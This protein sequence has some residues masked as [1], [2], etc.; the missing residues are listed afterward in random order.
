MK[1][2]RVFISTWKGK[3][4]TGITAITTVCVL[5]SATGGSDLFEIAKNID[6]FTSVYKELNTYY[7]DDVD[8]NK[9]MRTGIDAMLESLDPYTNYI[10]EA[11][12]EGYKFQITGNYGGIG[13]SIRP[14]NGNVTV[15]ECYEGFA[16]DKA[17]LKPGDILLEIDGK[18]VNTL[19][20]DGISDLL[21]GSPGT[22]VTLTIK[23]PFSEETQK[24]DIIREDIDIHNV[25]YYGFVEDGIGYIILTKF[26]EDAGANVADALKKLQAENPGM[27]GVILDLR[28]NPGGLLREAVNVS[29]VFIDKGE[30]VCSTLGKVKDWDKTFSALNNAIDKNIPLVVLINRGSASASEIVSGTIQDYDRGVIIGEKSYGKGLVQ[31]TVD[32]SYKTKLKLTTAKYYIP[33]GRCIQALDYAHRNDDGSVGK[34][35]DS[36]KTAFKTKN[37]RTVYDGGGIDP[38]VEVE[39]QEYRDI[40]ISLLRKNLIFNYATKYVAEHNS[41]AD[42]KH[43]SLSD[44]EYDAFVN[45]LSDKA[46]DYTTDTESDLDYLIA[47]AKSDNYYDA[48]ESDINDLRSKISH[49][50]EN[51]L[52]RS[53]DEIREE[54]NAEIASRYYYEK[55]RI[56]SLFGS[57]PDIQKGIE[58]LRDSAAYRSLLNIQ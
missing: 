9:L 20:D 28:G 50:K 46:Y 26:T 21:R 37:G 1:K 29:N 25:P 12:L 15:V 8:P 44:A 3:W 40:T 33:S 6:I 14:I 19:N 4:I 24:I 35:P 42:P 56:E 52:L 57:D 53:K 7:V 48:I 43:F 47:S 45:W 22:S 55:G 36:L 31:T 41:I 16:A 13:A 38:D 49:D 32:V 58:V 11:E 17:G 27:Q 2:F 34:M 54:L 5:V 30:E 51:D 23:K 39:Q 18:S 10:S